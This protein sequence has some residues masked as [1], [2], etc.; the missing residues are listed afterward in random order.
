MATRI[1]LLRTG[2]DLIEIGRVR[3]AINRHGG[4]FLHRVFTPAEIAAC[5]GKV[6]SLAGHFA[7]KEAAAKALGTGIGALGWLD[8]EISR[9]EKGE[10]LLVLHG[11]ADK[12]AK[13]LRLTAWSVSLSHS[14][15]QAIAMVVA[16]GR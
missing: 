9:G 16:I 13:K 5:A 2:I 3:A 4:R 1:M 11:V 8:I 14:E 10:P 6:E 12:L 15:E 7:A